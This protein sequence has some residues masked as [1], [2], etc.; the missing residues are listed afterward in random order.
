MENFKIRLNSPREFNIVRTWLQIL[1]HRYQAHP[2]Y[3]VQATINA[4]SLTSNVEGDDLAMA[5]FNKSCILP[6]TPHTFVKMNQK[7][8]NISGVERRL[9]AGHSVTGRWG[10][11][12]R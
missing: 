9:Y 3:P 2:L 11:T 10:G 8:L 12:I 6:L 4:F 7:C 5:G 1:L